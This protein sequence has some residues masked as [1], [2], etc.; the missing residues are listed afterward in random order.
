MNSKHVPK[1]I[2]ERMRG[3]TMFKLIFCDVIG[4]LKEIDITVEEIQNVITDGQGTDG[5]SIRGFVRIEESDLIL[6]PRLKSLRILPPIL[7]SNGKSVGVFFCDIKTPDGKP[8]PGDPRNCLKRMLRKAKKLGYTFFIGPEPE[9]FYFRSETDFKPIDQLGY[10][11]AD[12]HEPGTTL[13]TKTIEVLRELGIQ[14][15]CGHHEVAPSQHEID[16]KYQEA[17]T[18]ADQMLLFTWIVRKMARVNDLYATFLPKPL[19]GENGSGMHTHMSLFTGDKNAFYDN[20]SAYRLSATA[21]QFVAGLMKYVPEFTVITNPL[22]NSYKRI[23]PGYEAPCYISWGCRNRSSLIRIPNFKKGKKS[24]CRAELRSPDPSC[25][26]YLAFTVMLAAGLAGIDQNLKLTRPVE[27]NIFE[28]S[29]QDCKKMKI[30][31]LPGS[32]EAA[33]MQAEE[34]IFLKAALGSHIYNAF[35]DNKRAEWDSYRTYVSPW[36]LDHQGKRH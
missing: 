11:S 16:L 17:L 26:P 29:T 7:S 28:L 9:F 30:Q 6:Q 35:L 2:W 24:A 8:F 21:R 4:D 14:V 19:F 5:S 22:V 25:N 18:M 20:R 36:E 27:K 3:I 15:E 23:V 10:F 12:T 1:D 34:S 31:M 13:R 33:I 32:L